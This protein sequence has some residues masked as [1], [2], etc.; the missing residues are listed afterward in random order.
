[1]KFGVLLP[2]SP[3]AVPA[4]TQTTSAEQKSFIGVASIITGTAATLEDQSAAFYDS[5]AG[6]YEILR[7]SCALR[8]RH[9]ADHRSRARR[10]VRTERRRQDDAAADDGRTRGA[11]RRRRAEA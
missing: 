4:R 2:P 9:V 7:R 11:R 3:H 5:T 8:P 6:T 1:M 10:F